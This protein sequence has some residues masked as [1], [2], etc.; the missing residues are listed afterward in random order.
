MHWLR[1]ERVTM[2]KCGRG[3][4]CITVSVY[5]VATR[6][7]NWS[8][9]LHHT[10]KGGAAFVQMCVRVCAFVTYWVECG[11]QLCLII[12]NFSLH[13]LHISWTVSAFQ[14]HLCC[15]CCPPPPLPVLVLSPPSRRPLKSPGQRQT[16]RSSTCP[17]SPLTASWRNILLPWSCFTP[18]V[19]KRAKEHGLYLST[20]T[21]K[22]LLCK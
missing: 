17:M 10:H 2:R 6:S 15:P 19:S 5:A 3:G 22:I 1:P 14:S 9:V 11:L 20:A 4:P 7:W 13:R 16:L 18:L 21:R 8:S 12:F